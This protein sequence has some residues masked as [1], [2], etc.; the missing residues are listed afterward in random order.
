MVLK[1]LRGRLL[2]MLRHLFIFFIRIYQW[3]LSPFLRVLSG[4]N[5]CRFEPTCSHYAVEALRKHGSVAGALLATWRVLR[6]NP[7]GGLGPDPVP[8]ELPRWA[9]W[10][11]FGQGRDCCRGT[12]SSTGDQKAA[13]TEPTVAAPAEEKA[14]RTP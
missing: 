3:T 4:G 8:E 7:W 12:V 6:C 9:A 13:P 5:I 14:S 2:P 10:T 11:R 1:S